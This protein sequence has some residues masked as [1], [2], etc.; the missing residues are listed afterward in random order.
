MD[1]N[2]MKTFA[3]EKRTKNGILAETGWLWM[4]IPNFIYASLCVLKASA[5]TAWWKFTGIYFYPCSMSNRLVA[6]CCFFFLQIQH[7]FGW[8]TLYILPP[9]GKNLFCHQSKYLLDLKQM[10]INFLFAEAFNWMPNQFE[11]LYLTNKT[12]NV[13]YSF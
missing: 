2:K 12:K 10:S 11:I 5:I 4:A 8:K 3:T 9:L 1:T 6:C 7:N 13:P